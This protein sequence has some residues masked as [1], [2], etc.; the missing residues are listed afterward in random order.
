MVEP[1]YYGQTLVL[2]KKLLVGVQEIW[3]WEIGESLVDD[4]DSQVLGTAREG[5]LTAFNPPYQGGVRINW[6]FPLT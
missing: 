6:V 4:S 3:G 5:R 1:P 2:A